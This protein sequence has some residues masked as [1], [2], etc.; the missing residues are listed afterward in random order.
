MKH[1]SQSSNNA[2]IA[3]KGFRRFLKAKVAVYGKGVDVFP[4]SGWCGAIVFQAV[5]E[6]GDKSS[7]LC[8]K[9]VEEASSAYHDILSVSAAVVVELAVLQV[10]VNASLC[11]V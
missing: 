10:Q 4:L 1:N 5:D 3:S 9:N 6:V 8:L 11:C 7:L 2:T